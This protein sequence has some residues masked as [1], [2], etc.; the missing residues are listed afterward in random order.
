ME[1]DGFMTRAFRVRKGAHGLGRLVFIGYQKVIQA[2]MPKFLKEPFAAMYISLVN[3]QVR[4][5]YE[6]L[7]TYKDLE[8]L[9]ER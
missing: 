8:A 4:S 1:D 5:I 6:S 3:L 9:S 2:V 7:H